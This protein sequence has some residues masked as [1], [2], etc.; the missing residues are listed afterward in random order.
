MHVVD[1]AISMLTIVWFALL[2]V[3]NVLSESEEEEIRYEDL[4]FM[5]PLLNFLMIA[6]AK[7]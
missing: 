1:A 2:C 7:T 3:G 4:S 6:L 5:S